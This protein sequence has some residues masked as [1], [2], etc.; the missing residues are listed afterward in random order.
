MTPETKAR[1]FEP[2]F[3]TKDSTGTGLGLWVTA[4]IL[5]KHRAE[6]RVRSRQSASGHGTVFSIFIPTGEMPDLE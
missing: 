6:V 4:E 3:T 5:A 1:I 2:F